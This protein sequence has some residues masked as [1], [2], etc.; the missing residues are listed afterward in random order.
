MLAPRISSLPEM[1]E[2]RLALGGVRVANAKACEPPISRSP[3]AHC[4]TTS[5]EPG[6]TRTVDTRRVTGRPGGNV[7]NAV[8]TRAPPPDE[9]MQPT[10]GR[11]VGAARA[12]PAYVATNTTERDVVIP[13]LTG[14]PSV[15]RK[16]TSIARHAEA[17]VEP[18][19]DVPA[20]A[21]QL[22][23]DA[24]ARHGGGARHHDP[25]AGDGHAD[26]EPGALVRRACRQREDERRGAGDEERSERGRGPHGTRL[27]RKADSDAPVRSRIVAAAAN[28]SVISRS[29]L[30]VPRRDPS[31][32]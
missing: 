18:A 6:R 27:K 11:K 19:D 25:R 22:P 1:L 4:W 2:T 10:S 13:G 21:G 3:R 26:L 9:G 16:A 20:R 14:L 28:T 29:S 5:F 12:W 31:S 8:G 17:R 7:V 15:P 32:S 24:R 30:R 23:L